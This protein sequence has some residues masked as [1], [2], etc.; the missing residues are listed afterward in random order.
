M[1]APHFFILRRDPG[2]APVHI[3]DFPHLRMTFFR[4]RDV[5]LDGTALGPFFS[6]GDVLIAS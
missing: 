3:V 2:V 5:R 6:G 1:R 4:P